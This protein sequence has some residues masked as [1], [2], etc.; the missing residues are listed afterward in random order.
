M[1]C[2]LSSEPFLT[3][4]HTNCPLLSPDRLPGCGSTPSPSVLILRSTPP[5]LPPATPSY[6]L[7]D[8]E[9]GDKLHYLSIFRPGYITTLA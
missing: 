6:T 9:L 5:R 4:S 3:S 7:F 8:Q 2:W 1:S